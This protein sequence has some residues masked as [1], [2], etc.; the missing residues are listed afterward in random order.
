MEGGQSNGVGEVMAMPKKKGGS[1]FR[2]SK[3][4]RFVTEKFAKRHKN[5]TEKQKRR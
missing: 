4:G 5:T 1:L 2:S 3:T